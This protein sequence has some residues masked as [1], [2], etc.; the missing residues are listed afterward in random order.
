MR[1]VAFNI[2]LGLAAGA[3]LMAARP[4]EAI[5][6]D[7]QGLP[8]TVTA[9]EYFMVDIVVTGITSEIITAWDI[10]VA[11]DSAALANAFVAFNDFSFGGGMDTF[12]GDSIGAGLTDAWLV[13]LLSDA[14]IATI[15]CTGGCSATLKLASL[16]LGQVLRSL[17][18]GE[19]RD[20]IDVLREKSEGE[21]RTLLR[22]VAQDP[23]DCLADEELALIDHAAREARKQREVAAPG[24]QLGQLRQQRGAP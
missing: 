23:T 18:Q 8:A 12:F 4:A 2:C 16:G 17:A 19:A 21:L 24:A 3:L 15:Q 13:S 6:V 9:G 11:F 1:S 20:A 5:S 10:D 14:D 7:I 22:N